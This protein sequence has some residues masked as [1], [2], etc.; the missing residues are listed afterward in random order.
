MHKGYNLQIE[1]FCCKTQCQVNEKTT[2]RL[3]KSI[4]KRHIR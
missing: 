4:Y 3:E 1:N 2:H